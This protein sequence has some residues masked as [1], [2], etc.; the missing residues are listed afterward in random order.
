MSQ[1]ISIRHAQKT[2]ES[3]IVRF[4]QSMALETEALTLDESILTKGVQSVFE[5][6]E[7]GFYLVCEVDGVVRGSLMITYEW[8][9]W[10]NG[11]FYWVQSV[12]V[13]KAFRRIGIYKSLYQYLQE[14]LKQNQDVAGMRL[15]VEKD[16][17]KAQKTYT[18]VGM[19]RTNYLLFEEEIKKE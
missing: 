19:K 7:K 3:I 17:E 2:D 12:Y 6:P 18:K 15:Y 1:T 11:T 16:N 13:E 8:S 9:D 4:N 10:R 14:Q 5:N